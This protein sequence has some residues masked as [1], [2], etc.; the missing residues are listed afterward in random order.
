MIKRFPI[1]LI[2]LGLLSS[3]VFSQSLRE[4]EPKTYSY[5]QYQPDHGS[6]FYID[7]KNRQI[8][9]LQKPGALG[10]DLVFASWDWPFNRWQPPTF[11]AY[12][13]TGDGVVDPFM[14]QCDNEDERHALIGFI[15]DF[16]QTQYAVYPGIDPGTGFP[17]RTGWNSHLIMDYNT[18]ISYIAIYDFLNGGVINN[19]LWQVDLLDDPSTA[20]QLTD[21]LTALEGGWARIALDGNG[22]FW[23]V[24]DAIPS[25][26]ANPTDIAASTDGGATFVVVDS[27][28]SN[29]ANFWSTEFS[30]DPMIQANGQKI[31]Y[32]TKLLRGGNLSELGYFDP[33]VTDP[34]SADG[35]YHWY[36]TDGGGT[37]QGETISLD[38][39]ANITNRPDY[40]NNM[41]SFN[42]GSF[43]VDPNEVT[44]VAQS[45]VN[46]VGIDPVSGDTI[47]VYPLL[48]WNDRDK[49]WMSL[50]IPAVE[51]FQYDDLLSI[52][53]AIGPAH[54][55][56]MTNVTGELLVCM[57][58]LPQ[59]TG[60]PGESSIN[61]FT[62]DA[63]DYYYTDVYFAYSEDSGVTWSTPA[64]ALTVENECNIWPYIGAVE[65]LNGTATVH[66]AAL[67]DDVPGSNVLGSNAKSIGTWRYYTQ[68]FPTILGIGDEIGTIADFQL[69][70]NYPNPFNPGTVIKY[71]VPERSNV[72]IKVFDMLGAEVATLVNGLQEADSYEI[73]FDASS[74]SS[75]MYI[76]S[77]K[78]GEFSASK[79]M[80]LLK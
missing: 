10:T 31:S 33:D 50:E 68:E 4:I 64:L 43:F 45:G 71:T 80:M 20:T 42:M 38:G 46:S 57:W 77:I 59:F 73:N 16:G 40:E 19:H 65:I 78:A 47:N 35:E 61:I 25:G 54:P 41:S 75:G 58:G 14:I 8:K 36:S 7:Y 22:I 34:D 53:N 44:H 17:W 9:N 27:V 70:Q 79:K 29:D 63:T 3:V 69:E 76:Y 67:Y 18:G 5:D 74:L 49:D 26:N 66:Y 72:T 32:I 48:Y 37:W 39:Q 51:L 30:N 6:A 15:D 13:F 12:D 23:M 56:L 11:V 1:I 62:G 52:G 55:V 28:G 2:V 60:A 24:V 21:S